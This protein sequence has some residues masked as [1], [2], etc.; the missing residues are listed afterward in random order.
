LSLL[1]LHADALI[2]LGALG[3]AEKVLSSLSD[4]ATAAHDRRYMA[5]AKLVIADCAWDSKA[6]SLPEITR[7]IHESVEELEVVR[8]PAGLARAL[9]IASTLHLLSN[10]YARAE[11]SLERAL[12]LA[13]RVGAEQQSREIRLVLLATTLWGPVRTDEGVRRCELL[14]KDFPTSMY[15]Q[16][17]TWKHLAGLKAMQGFVDE[18]RSLMESSDALFLDLGMRFSLV[19]S[20]QLKGI[21]ELLADEPGK[22]EVVLRLGLQSMLSM[23]EKGFVPFTAALLAR[24]LLLQGRL[25]ESQ[26]QGEEIRRAQPEGDITAEVCWNSTRGL[27]LG[28]QGD[29]QG[30]RR[31]IQ[32]AVDLAAQG[33]D[34][35]AHADTLMDLAALELWDGRPGRAKSQLEKAHGLYREKRHVVGL[36]R[37][38]KQLRGLRSVAEA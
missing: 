3:E 14:V 5:L 25:Q 7:N 17:Q 35:A 18:A 19:T 13:N 23:G 12:L 37:S 31:L 34:I 27:L 8:D 6:Q 2:N 33:D 4:E 16:A 10:R 15:V 30:G 9:T 11:E 20:M 29:F 36:R 24:S 28:K 21:I 32:S 38:S 1:L 26:S 22:A